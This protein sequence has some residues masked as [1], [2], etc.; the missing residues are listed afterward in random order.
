MS[1]HNTI[2]REAKKKLGSFYTPN[3]LISV[4]IAWAIRS[5]DDVVL[6]PS[7]GGCGFVGES[8][9]RLNKLGCLFPEKNIYGC[10]IDINAV[11][12]LDTVLTNKNGN[13]LT[14]D[15]L[16]TNKKSFQNQSFDVVIGNPPYVSNHNISPEQ[17][18]A[19]LNICR[20]LD[21]TISKRASLWAYFVLHS[22]FFISEG[23]RLALVLPN[24]FLQAD[25]A[26]EIRAHL[27]S[28]FDLIT[29]II[30]HD[31][32]FLSE[33]TDE[34]TVVLL[35]EGFHAHTKN[36]SQIKIAEAETLEDLEFQIEALCCHK[37]IGS[38]FD[39]KLNH[40]LMRPSCSERFE[41][42]S[43]S[44]ECKIVGD[45]LSIK[46]GIVTGDNKFFVINKD[47]AKEKGLFPKYTRPLLAKITNAP[48]LS[49]TQRDHQATLNAKKPCLLIRT[50][51]LKRG[52][53]APIRDYLSSYP[54]QK[55]KNVKTFQKRSLWHAP[56]DFRIPDA[57]FTYMKQ[58]CPR[59][60]LNSFQLNCTN[61]IH[62][63]YFNDDISSHE[64]QLIALSFLSSF[65]QLSAEIEGKG[66]GSGVL[67]LEPNAVKRIKILIPPSVNFDELTF[68]YFEADKCLRSGDL[69]KA[70]AIADDFILSPF[71]KQHKTEYKN[72]FQK[73][74]QLTQNRRQ[75]IRVK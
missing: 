37:Q 62:R 64:R 4:L 52:K 46:I 42:L 26:T 75:H 23:G 63:I 69:K 55:R 59:I 51:R 67:K 71:E 22:T 66:Y 72:V 16:T 3:E 24:S 13:F 19:A 47:Y 27:R 32:L 12:Y 74:L 31:R 65:S 5:K 56:D 20:D 33:G 10:D 50:E 38:V 43:K 2:D 15:F 39:S 70:T 60:I 29:A 36:K 48:G 6:E 40:A 17:K 11:A 9:K 41:L 34:N 73:E 61:S 25:Y 14:T 21:V 28:H 35:A 7:F 54:R 8:K 53:D 45:L 44:K 30:L 18:E 1:Y 57:F 58:E 49:F 68:A